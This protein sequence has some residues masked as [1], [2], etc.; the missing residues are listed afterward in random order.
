MNQLNIP[1]PITWFRSAQGPPLPIISSNNPIIKSERVRWD[2]SLI[3]RTTGKEVLFEN[4]QYSIVIENCRQPNYFSEKLIDCLRMK[5]LPI[6]YGCPNISEYFDISGWII[7]ETM[8]VQELIDK[9]KILP[10]YSEH[11]LSIENNYMLS[12]KYIDY[13]LNIRNCVIK[14]M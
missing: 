12:E 5:T 6:Y 8:N 11:T 10:L 13:S 9:C 2:D 1:L 7:L 14:Y 3:D 4:F